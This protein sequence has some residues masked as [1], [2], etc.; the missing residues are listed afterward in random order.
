MPTA[1][2]AALRTPAL[3]DAPEEVTLLKV[4]VKGRRHVRVNR[5]VGSSIRQ[6]LAFRDSAEAA[7]YVA[8]HRRR[9]SDPNAAK[10]T[11]STCTMPLLKALNLALEEGAGGLALV[12][13][14][15]DPEQLR[16]RFVPAH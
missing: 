16:G 3:F 8:A 4:N 13:D 15:R 10:P 11:W 14:S 5:V 7:A 1:D 2:P 12:T 6:L 9:P